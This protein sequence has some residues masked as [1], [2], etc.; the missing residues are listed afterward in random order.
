MWV[1]ETVR[2]EASPSKTQRFV[3]EIAYSC[4]MT[5]WPATYD[6]CD[7][8]NVTISYMSRASKCDVQWILLLL[9]WD[10]QWILLLQVS[11][12]IYVRSFRGLF[13]RSFHVTSYLW[14][15][16]LLDPDVIAL[17]F[18][19]PMHMK[20][21]WKCTNCFITRILPG[22]P[23]M[24]P[25]YAFRMSRLPAAVVWPQIKTLKEQIESMKSTT[26]VSLNSKKSN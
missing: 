7:F 18:K 8:F 17:H 24:L 10:V 4:P 6:I 20:P 22:L 21:F 16:W 2:V 5:T 11:V 3:Q 19:P 9:V 12:A 15:L 26:N 14:H 23:N 25:K 13:P 1:K